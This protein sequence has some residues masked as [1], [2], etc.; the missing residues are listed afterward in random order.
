[1]S[2][3]T[4][5]VTSELGPGVLVSLEEEQVLLVWGVLE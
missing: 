3:R 4:E 1:M 5:S 2:L